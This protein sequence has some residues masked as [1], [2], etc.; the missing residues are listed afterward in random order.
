MSPVNRGGR[1]ELGSGTVL[2]AAV[3]SVVV[4]LAAAAT[5]VAGYLVSH[6]RARSAADL[7]ALS[8]AAV[9]ARGEDAC[10]QARRIARRNGAR[11]T[12]CDQVGDS[13]DFVVTVRVV[14]EV[15]VRSPGLPRRVQAEAHAGRVN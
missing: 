7:A 15:G 12:R 14:V 4:A 5:V 6:H 11:V 8:G 10:D 13:V 1:D 9:H 3:M 2:M